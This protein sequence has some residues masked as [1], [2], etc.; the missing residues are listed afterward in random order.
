MIEPKWSEQ[1]N[2]SVQINYSRLEQELSDALK[3]AGD[4]KL[5]HIRDLMAQMGESSGQRVMITSYP[6][7]N[8]DV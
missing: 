8:S 4:E 1:M 6:A 2:H 3:N 7:C 5:R